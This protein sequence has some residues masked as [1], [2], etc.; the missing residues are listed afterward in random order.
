[1]DLRNCLEIVEKLIEGNKIQENSSTI[2]LFMVQDLL[3]WALIKSNKFRKNI[4]KFNIIKA[5]EA[6]IQVQID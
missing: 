1:M 3:D 6:V 4:Q 2:M 5:V